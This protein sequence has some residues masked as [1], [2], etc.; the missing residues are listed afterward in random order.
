MDNRRCKEC[1]NETELKKLVYKLKNNIYNK[2]KEIEIV[3]PFTSDFIKNVINRI[4][5]CRKL[6]NI[7]IK[8]RNFYLK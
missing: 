1:N 6:K 2:K 3:K 8:K 5:R 4:A 7:F